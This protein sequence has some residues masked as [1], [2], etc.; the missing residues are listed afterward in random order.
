M[1]KKTCA[2]A[3]LKYGRVIQGWRLVGLIVLIATMLA[4]LLFSVVVYCVF[5]SEIDLNV[6]EIFYCLLGIVFFLV[7]FIIC[8]TLLILNMRRNHEISLWLK[9]S[10]LIHADVI[11][12]DKNIKFL[13]PNQV[14]VKFKFKKKKIRKLSRRGNIFIGYP[15]IFL[16]FEGENVP[17]LYSPKFDEVI[18]T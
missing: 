9:D 10:I 8:L 6:E 1:I 18:F 11:R 7:G 14:L 16:K 2:R 5:K 13:G 12:I 3:T 15:H 17:I 4:T